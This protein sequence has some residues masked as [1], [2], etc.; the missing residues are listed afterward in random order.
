VQPFLN[1]QNLEKDFVVLNWNI[2][3]KEGIE[4]IAFEN[5][6]KEEYLPV[7][8]KT[9]TDADIYL[10]KSDRG[11]NEGNYSIY[12]IFKSLEARNEWWPEK[13]VSSD[14]L[15]KAIA[16][17]KSEEEKFYSMANIDSWNDWLI[18]K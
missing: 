1:A 18:L 14:K 15:K 13:G 2:S 4:V 17:M 10:L 6:I 11:S 16:N 9:I 5:F 8:R 7:L 3:P 12:V